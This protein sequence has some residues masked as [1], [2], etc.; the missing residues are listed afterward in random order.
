[1][2]LFD[3][4]I[5]KMKCDD[6]RITFIHMC[7]TFDKILLP[8]HIVEDIIGN[9]DVETNINVM[10]R[11]LAYDDV[12]DNMVLHDSGYK[13]SVALIDAILSIYKKFIK[14][15]IDY[16]FSNCSFYGAELSKVI[17]DAISTDLIYNRICELFTVVSHGSMFG[18]YSNSIGYI[19]I[20]KLLLDSGYKPVDIDV[21]IIFEIC[22][23]AKN[24]DTNELIQKFS[25]IFETYYIKMYT[26]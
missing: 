21:D 16:N 11:I 23:L 8:R 5:N 1:M 19:L 26:T 22:R 6:T 20:T 13:V 18:E 24:N 2:G 25:Y 17:K 12:Y 4:A 9:K 3:D 15:R 14:D 10:R 7:L